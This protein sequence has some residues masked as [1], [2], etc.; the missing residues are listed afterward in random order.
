MK[1]HA[2]T[3]S[4][5]GGNPAGVVFEC[6]D[7]TDN[8]MK[9]I[10]KQLNVSETAFVFPSTVADVKVRFFS[11]VVEVDLCGHATVATFFMMG[12]NKTLIGKKTQQLTQETKAGVLPV[13]II[14][15]DD[16]SVEKVLMTQSK[17]LYKNIYFDI[18]LIADAL[19]IS[20]I[21]IDDSLPSQ[22]VS[23]GLFTLP[24]CIKSFEMLSKIKPD[25]QK[26]KTIC[27]Q[28]GVGSFH[29]FTFETRQPDS[30]YHARNFAPFYG[31][32]EDPVTGT[33]NGAVCSYLQHHKL[34]KEGTVICEQG[35][36]LGR[37]GRVFVELRQDTVKVGGQA[38]LAEK[39]TLEISEAL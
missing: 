17:P 16:G 23:T 1:V 5:E 32:D 7:L 4:V 2:F 39:Q 35:D 19:R 29:V 8:Q 37:P 3:D 30:V 11:P 26:I 14:F 10:S 27:A 21:E 38:V 31:I 22:I 13:D 15:S 24:V 36:I 9:Q 12:L 25:F 20:P 6:P 33:A 18:S 28:I 34:I